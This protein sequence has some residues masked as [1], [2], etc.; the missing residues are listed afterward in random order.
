[1]CNNAVQAVHF[2][3]STLSALAPMRQSPPLSAIQEMY[4]GGVENSRRNVPMGAF[5]AF[6]CASPSA[7]APDRM[8]L[9]RPCQFGRSGEQGHRIPA[10]FCRCRGF[11]GVRIAGNPNQWHIDGFWR[12]FFQNGFP[13]SLKRIITFDFDESHHRFFCKGYVDS[14]FHGIASACNAMDSD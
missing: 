4:R 6:S 3:T 2:E 14:S 7:P 10:A 1:M 13:G 9:G 12:Y 8:P 11:V 5:T